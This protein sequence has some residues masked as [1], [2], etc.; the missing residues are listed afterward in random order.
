MSSS[1]R[2]SPL[3]AAGCAVVALA[4]A[5]PAPAWADP[6]PTYETLLERI[7][8][9][10]VNIEA[11]AL[12]EAAEARVR[13]ARVRPNPQ[14]GLTA[15]GVLGSGPY[16]GYSNAETS[17]ALTQDLELWG[18]RGARVEVARGEAG[19][20]ALR[21]DLAGIDAAGRL[22][23]VYAEA[24]AADRRFQLAKEALTITLADARAALL[25]VEEGREPLLRGIQ[26][27]TEAASARASLDEAGAEREAAF[28]RLTATAMLPA[29]VTS[30]D[31]G[32]LDRA[33]STPDQSGAV[34]PVVRVA[35]AER[36]TAERRIRV[37]RI[38]ARPNVSASVGVRRYEAEDAT[39]LT[40]GVSMPLPLFDRN[41]G[42]IQAAQAEF[43]AANARL[44][45]ARLDEAADRSAAQAR[46]NASASR[47]GATDAGVTSAEEAYRLSRLGFEA[48]RISQLE[49]RASRAAL[50]SAR[51]A[52]VDA[53]PRA[54]PG[55]N[56][57]RAP[58]KPHP[59]WSRPVKTQIKTRKTWLMAGAAAAVIVIGGAAFL[60]T[61]DDSAPSTPVQA[62]AEAGDDGEAAG[63]AK[64]G[65]I[66]LTPAQIDA[67]GI[68]VMAVGRGGGGETRLAGRVEPMIDARA[69]VAASVGGRVERVL[70]APGQ[71]VRAGQALAVLVSGEAATFRADADA[72]AAAADAARRAYQRNDS[73]SSQGVVAR[74]EVE[75]SRAQS[76]SA[77]AA[78]RA[79]RARAVGGRGPQCI[80]SHQRLQ[81]DFGRGDVGSG[82]SGRIR[83][84][85]RRD[86]RGHQSCPCG[87]GVQCAACA[88]RPGSGG[89]VV[90]GARA[91]R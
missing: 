4:T 84:P 80:G 66:T 13:Q 7:G 50:I 3:L 15:D 44:D 24:E 32:V 16:D 12:L 14:I 10:P 58:A 55:G 23:L 86:R 59:V 90:A 28:A 69:A 73:L 53:P 79:A 87:T 45:G 78:A 77:D 82:R 46:L 54:G 34:S 89:F 62:S 31:A 29:A 88:G 57:P 68:T 22:A 48:G 27:E 81:P 11:G 1:H 63:E 5:A 75:T 20:V 39:A 72:A 9:T 64:E 49:L 36:E 6:A 26:A 33:P 71:S 19:A 65:V 8:Q 47:V 42:N 43:R 67:A 2:R 17:L 38:A 56:R 41:R 40:F 21:R 37:E 18:R 61:R 70:V 60:M 85:R 91:D 52:A 25:L 35:E 51:N 83:A 74:Q 76:L 30:I